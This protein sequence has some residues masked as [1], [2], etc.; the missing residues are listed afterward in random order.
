MSRSLLGDV[1]NYCL[2]GDEPVV[3]RERLSDGSVAYNVDWLDVAYRRISIR[4]FNRASAER[5]CA[6]LKAEAHSCEARA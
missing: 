2:S 4:C 3:A 5:L 6:A 1:F